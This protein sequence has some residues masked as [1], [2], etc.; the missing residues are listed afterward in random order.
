[1][2]H[3]QSESG[4]G[5]SPSNANDTERGKNWPGLVAARKRYFTITNSGGIWVHFCYTPKPY[6]STM[7]NAGHEND[8][9]NLARA[10]YVRTCVPSVDRDFL[11]F[12]R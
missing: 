10:V 12:S 9:H 6:R 11:P 1:M 2:T 5:H 4:H 3:T 8:F 7:G